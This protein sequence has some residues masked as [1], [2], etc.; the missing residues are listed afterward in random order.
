MDKN[1]Q[2]KEKWVNDKIRTVRNMRAVISNW[3]PQNKVTTPL[4]G[5]PSY[6]NS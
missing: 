6:V 2:K 1:F 3:K 5:A 4:A